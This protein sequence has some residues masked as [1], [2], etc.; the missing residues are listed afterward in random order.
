MEIVTEATAVSLPACVATIG[1]FD[2]V[3]KGHQFLIEQ[4]YTIAKAEGLASC[5]ITFSRHPRQVLDTDYR[6]RLLT[7]LSQKIERFE[8]TPIDYCVLLPFTKELSMLSAREFMEILHRVYHVQTLF[9]GYDHHFGHGQDEGF[10]QYCE[11]GKELGMRVMHSKALIEDGVSVSSTLIRSCLLE[12]DIHRANA[13]LGYNY[14]LNG[15]VV[16]GRKLGRTIGFPTA[17]I[18]PL[19]EEKLL[20]AA[21]VYA[22]YVYIGKE[23]YSGM[24]NIGSCPTVN[25]DERPASIE[26]HILNFTG[27]LYQKLVKVEFLDYIRPEVKFDSVEALTEQLQRDKVTVKKLLNQR[28]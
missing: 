22:V 11:Y 6:P 28:G 5:L 14:Y 10:Q 20:P 24:L 23:C 8:H 4:V 13:Y 16:D 3:H 2:G 7:C 25:T 17:N 19:C 21:G 18:Q 12:G 1:C 27:D 26:V 15:R 9:V